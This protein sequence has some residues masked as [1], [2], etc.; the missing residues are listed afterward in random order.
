MKIIHT[1]DWHIGKI[2]HRQD[3]E[4]EFRLFIEDFIR[5]VA[6][7]KIDVV[8]I[9]G[10]VFDQANPANKDLKVYYHAITRL[11][12][13]GAKVIITGGN[14]DSIG[15]LNAP[16]PIFTSLD[17]HVIGGA[18]SN[19][20]DEIIPVLDKQGNISCI[21]LAV[22]FLRDRD[23]RQAIAINLV[24]PNEN[25]TAQAIKNHYDTLVQITKEKYPTDIPIIAMG[26]L[27]MQ[28]AAT[29]ESER[30]IHIGNLVGMDVR[31]MPAEIDYFALGHIHKPQRV[32]GNERIRYCGS[33]IFLDFSEREYEKQFIE[34]EIKNKAIVAI[35][36]VPIKTYRKMLKYTGTTVE[37][38]VALR[39]YKHESPLQSY[40]ELEVIEEN[41]D[42]TTFITFQKTVEELD[43]TDFKILKTKAT[44]TNTSSAIPA[45]TQSILDFKPLD[46]LNHVLKNNNICK[47]SE[48][49]A[50]HRIYT[51]IMDTIEDTNNDAEAEVSIEQ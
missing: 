29:S 42:P 35:K 47:N 43:Q 10:D 23:L 24:D 46:I 37:I 16:R 50:F 17:I 51:E 8:L 34:I 40:I 14:H 12:S 1:A 20:A 39:S 27:Y 49:T 44:K 15:L 25:T 18:R 28:G 9:S 7:E 21:L 3:L 26:H 2:L 32:G 4:P 33:P 5:Y 36:T 48:I 13:A 45:L 22:P 38:L 19:L 31:M 30:D 41:L 6:T 11:S